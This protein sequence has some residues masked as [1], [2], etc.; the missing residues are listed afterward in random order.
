MNEP[1]FNPSDPT[2]DQAILTQL[3]ENTSEEI[4]RAV[5]KNPNSPLEVLRML[6]LKYPE[7]LLMNPVLTLWEITSPEEIPDLI[8]QPVLLEL[9]NSLRCKNEPLPERFF[10]H[11]RLG[12]LASAALENF[13]PAIYKQ[14]PVDSDTAIRKIFVH[15]VQPHPRCLFFF[16][17]CPDEIWLA[18]ANDPCEEVAIKFSEL[19]GKYE[20]SESPMRPIFTE[21]T[22]TVARRKSSKIHQ[23]LARCPH[24]PTE[25]ID[26][27]LETGDVRT[28][29][30]LTNSR[31][32]SLAAQLKL[33]GDP[34]KAV[35]LAMAKAATQD[36]V[37]RAFRMDD[38]ST[39][40][41]A[42][43]A[44]KKTAND[45][46]CRIVCEACPEVQE[47]LG[48]SATYFAPPFYFEIKP[49]LTSKTRAIIC[50]RL[51]LH[52]DILMDL[53]ND[54][55]D[56]VRLE[57]VKNLE[58]KTHMHPSQFI[59]DVVA[60][61]LRDPSE[62]V[63]MEIINHPILSNEQA[64]EL[65][66]DPS[67]SVRAGMATY[68]LK[69]LKFHRRMRELDEYKALYVEFAPR[70][71]AM[72]HDP[73]PKVRIDL[74]RGD[75]T[76][77]HAL[78]RLYE[79]PYEPI[80]EIAANASTLSLGYYLD[81]GLTISKRNKISRDFVETLTK[82]EN[83]FLRHIA[84]K[85]SLAKISDLR[86]LTADS[87]PFVAATA[88]NKLE[89]REYYNGQNFDPTALEP[90]PELALA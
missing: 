61:F 77:P 79:D 90:T 9:F 51:G 29:T 36:E 55:D 42:V 6:W 34:S 24:L 75:E 81:N 46:R 23:Q 1:N 26:L 69:K 25:T 49:H 84:S 88:T 17:C 58:H 87:N 12:L 80:R 41:K 19:L 45:V 66:S 85:S 76:P 28:K 30:L 89:I 11:R 37:L 54:S 67:A 73:A 50:G 35:R 74:A 27:L 33:A 44:N 64:I 59:K 57:L 2:L 16:E 21:A 83:P 63:R 56:S 18:L 60:C 65:L 70:L 72:A 38:D 40:L 13:D 15:A 22:L 47:V 43:L 39:V 62:S 10:S 3:A 48:D 52:R 71:I 5:A 4:Q 20:P 82:S 8:G 14:F 78:W 86:R 53:L 32:S 31:L 68:L 7:C